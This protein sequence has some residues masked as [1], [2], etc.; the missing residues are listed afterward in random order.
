TP[1]GHIFITKGLVDVA[2]SE[3][4]LAGII[5]HELSHIIL[6]HG[7]SIIN[8][9]KITDEMADM[10]RR[11]A[12]MS[13]SPG[14]QR[15]LAMRNSVAGLL[16]TLMK[17]GYSKPQEFEADKA[18]VAL[19]A[20][21]GYDPNGLLDVLKVLQRVQGTQKGGFNS[22]HP[23]PQERIANLGDPKAMYRI[24]DTSSYRTRRFAHNVTNK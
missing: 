4:G 20:E 16:D 11:G 7:I 12:A 18:A 24:T 13:G 19:L 5:A 9:M 6:K 21:S 8:D 1:G 17:N 10:A 2:S 22:T 3:D 14:A 23:T 15:A